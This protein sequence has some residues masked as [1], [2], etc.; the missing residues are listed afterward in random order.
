M[1]HLRFNGNLQSNIGKLACLS[2]S[3]GVCV[4]STPNRGIFTDFAGI[5]LD[6]FTSMVAAIGA[7][8]TNDLGLRGIIPKKEDYQLMIT[9]TTIVTGK[10]IGRAHV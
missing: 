7:G 5:A 9:G 8:Q 3:L 1:E 4:D 2:F 10:Q 6:K